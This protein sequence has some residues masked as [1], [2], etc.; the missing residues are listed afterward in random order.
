[1]RSPRRTAQTASALMV[2]LALVSAIAVFGAS[3]SQV[4]PPAS[5]DE[6]IAAD[7][8]VTATTAAGSG[9]FSNSVPRRRGLGPRGHRRPRPSISGKFE[10]RQTVTNLTAVSDSRPLGRP[11]FCT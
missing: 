1:M 10:F 11:S 3:L 8:I 9:T 7:L 4:R 2:G 6:A 5:V